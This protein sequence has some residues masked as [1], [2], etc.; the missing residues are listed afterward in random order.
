VEN[1]GKSGLTENIRQSKISTQEA[2]KKILEY[3][4]K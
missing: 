3:L 4:E 2:E 1:F